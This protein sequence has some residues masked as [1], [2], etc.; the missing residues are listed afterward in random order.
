MVPPRAPY[1]PSHAPFIRSRHCRWHASSSSNSD[2]RLLWFIA[3]HSPT[4]VHPPFTRLFPSWWTR[5]FN[6][7]ISRATA[8][9]RSSATHAM[10]RMPDIFQPP[11]IIRTRPDSDTLI[12]HLSRADAAD[13]CGHDDHRPEDDEHR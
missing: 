9:A 12:Q 7:S 8:V 5:R 6:L 4:F 2:H 11:A 10:G 1:S 13:H 3:F